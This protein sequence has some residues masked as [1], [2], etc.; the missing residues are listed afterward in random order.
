MV[1]KRVGAIKKHKLKIGKRLSKKDVDY[2]FVGDRDFQIFAFKKGTNP[3]TDAISTIHTSYSSKRLE[4]SVNA[5]GTKIELQKKGIG[6]ELM[7]RLFGNKNS[8]FS[9]T[10]VTKEGIKLR[11]KFPSTF[12]NSLVGGA[13]VESTGGKVSILKSKTGKVSKRVVKS[14]SPSTIVKFVRVRG[15]IIPIRR[16]K[17]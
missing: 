4:T 16:K 2:P 8:T 15:R 3:D 12:K 9:G 6:F 13:A 10:V 1:S 5:T 17:K 7:K 11:E 14:N